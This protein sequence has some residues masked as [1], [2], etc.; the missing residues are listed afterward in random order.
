MRRAGIAEPGNLAEV[1][2]ARTAQDVAWHVRPTDPMTLE[3]EVA[4]ICRDLGLAN[5]PQSRAFV[6][7]VLQLEKRVAA[8]EALLAAQPESAAFAPAVPKRT[9]ETR[10]Q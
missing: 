6:M 2:Q 3:Q 4:W 5:Q 1:K 9:F 8:L 7:R 10:E